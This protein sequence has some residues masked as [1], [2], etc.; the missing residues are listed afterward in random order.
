MA[1]LTFVLEQG[2]EV[3]VPLVDAAALTLGRGDDNDVVVD[4][5]RV[6]AHHAA[7]ER[8]ADGS[9]EVRDLNSS[10]GTFVNGE[11]V[12]SRC[13]HDGDTVA[14][15]PLT[16]VVDLEEFQPRLNGR[17]HGNSNGNS[18]G[19]SRAHAALLQSLSKGSRSQDHD[20]RPAE[21][22]FS[23][24][25]VAVSE[26][27]V[28][29]EAEKTRLEGEVAAMQAGLREQT[30]A[31]ARLQHDLAAARAT[32]QSWQEGAA[33]EMREHG[34]RMDTLRADEKRLA[35]VKAAVAEAAGLHQQWTEAVQVL[36][37]EHEE[38]DLE[39]QRLLAAEAAAR[40][41]IQ[42]LAAHKDQELARLR[43]MQEERQHDEAHLESL[44]QQVA[45]QEERHKHIEDLA[46][47][48][49]DQVRLAEKKLAD[50]AD[51][52]TRM[53]AHVKELAG[54]EERLNQALARKQEADAQHT[55]LL[56]A[57][58]M[59]NTRKQGLESALNELEA[60]LRSVQGDLKK[61]EAALEETRTAKQRAEEA[62]RS[63]QAELAAETTR[64]QDATA[65]RT[66]IIQQCEELADTRQELAELDARVAAAEQRQ[67]AAQ[68]DIT[69]K[70]ARLQELED[71]VA[72]FTGKE[73][74]AKG[75]L[76]VLHAR[77]NDL[78]SELGKLA[79]AEHATR[80]R[81]EEI[82]QL[83][84]EGEAEQ[85]ALDEQHALKLKT[86][87]QELQDLE[88]KLVPLRDW[89]EAMDQ[90]Y[91][92]LAEL[93]QDSKEA[94]ELWREIEKEKEDL[95]NLISTARSQAA[96]G[97]STGLK[98]PALPRKKAPP[99]VIPDSVI[100]LETIEGPVPGTGGAAA[101]VQERT[102]R[103]RLN[104]LRESVQREESRLEFL[105]Q[106]RGRQEVRLRTGGPAGEAMQREHDRHLEA[107]IRHDEEQLRA[108][109][110]HLDQAR[111]EEEK[112][113]ARIAEMEHKLAELHT[114]IAEAERHRSD[115]RHQA[116]LAHT[117]LRNFE[118]TLERLKKTKA[119]SAAKVKA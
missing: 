90:L 100:I 55:T 88:S 52:R 8:H 61:T 86:R 67:H 60:R 81:F 9:L 49:E 104:H 12:Q 11:R 25:A 108:L 77:E 76:E 1:K 42:A 112:R 33:R 4:D 23:P 17:S 51:R 79:A 119:E 111:A 72:S 110:Q 34:V 30:A 46:A 87:Q 116:D 53:E 115:L 13:I 103:T 3:V 69:R 71:S 54:T 99:Q 118:S 6:S 84:T 36:S 95:K 101:A 82:R 38:K 65:R 97:A 19:H 70:E 92:R 29:L 28:R 7:L 26:E 41:E 78:R 15:G 45:A 117:E 83:I 63:V 16:A 5:A 48:R 102:L 20:G 21:D 75:R 66:E 85:Q 113:Q 96:L 22:G 56:A 114:G 24:A 27:L 94:R 58:G 98:K 93:P 35:Q 91:A 89:K 44:R 59:L 39:V 32:Q 105:R 14:F 31:H 106:E 43:Q 109:N 10:A 74:A 73:D 2:E 18:N 47:A 62:L 68:E 40:H 50:I 37:A 107:R 57:I 80:A 64:L